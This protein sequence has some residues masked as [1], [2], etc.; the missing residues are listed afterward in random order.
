MGLTIAWFVQMTFAPE[1]LIGSPSLP[2][3]ND[4]LLFWVYLVLMNTTWVVVPAW[5][6]YDSW[7]VLSSALPRKRVQKA[8]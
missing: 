1:W 8:D 4:V 7:R 6:M 3:R 2:P 5:L